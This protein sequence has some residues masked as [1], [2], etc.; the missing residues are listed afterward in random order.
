MKTRYLSLLIILFSCYTSK[1][2][3]NKG[4]YYS[5]VVKSVNWLKQN[6]SH[7]SSRETLQKAY[8]LA[9]KTLEQ[10]SSNV[11]ASNDVFKNK[12]T[13]LMYNQINALYDLIN[14]S[15]AALEVITEPKN[16]YKEIGELREKAAE[17]TYAAGIQSMMVGNREGSRKA[18]EYF[19]ETISFAP[20][21]K[22]VVEMSTQAEKEGTL[23]IVWDEN[24]R[25]MW[26]RSSSIISA[27][28]EMPF[29]DLKRKDDFIYS[30]DSEKKNFELDMNISVLNYSEGQPSVTSN[31][32]EVIDSV[33]VG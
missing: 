30:A 32:V 10:K 16:Y 6:P 31:S 14:S 22:D 4:D 12:S 11:Q 15:P 18:V 24:G 20:Q 9:L 19:K 2:L 33:K 23:T 5:A 13:L 28:D 29:V 7:K 3:Y 17:E 27:I 26:W 25:G 21:Y 1:E 8:P